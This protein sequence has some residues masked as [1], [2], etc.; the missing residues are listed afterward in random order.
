VAFGASGGDIGPSASDGRH[1]TQFFGDFVKR[2][3]LREP[4]KSIHYSLFVRHG[5]KL[6]L[7]GFEGKWRG[8]DA[9]RN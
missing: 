3:L 4:L 5:K 1:K 7:C 2:C 9:R 8:D 6:L